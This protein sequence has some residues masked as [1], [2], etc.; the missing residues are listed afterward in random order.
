MLSYNDIMLINIPKLWMKR[1]V[2]LHCFKLT[3][4]F[5]F[6]NVSNFCIKWSTHDEKQ[7]Q[8][9]LWV[10]SKNWLVYFPILVHQLYS[11]IH[12][13]RCLALC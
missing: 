11:S 2:D 12:S 7:V 4:M 8:T 13:E 6:V 9:A 1:N 10:V 5:F 3:P